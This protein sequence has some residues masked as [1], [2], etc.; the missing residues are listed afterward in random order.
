MRRSVWLVLLVLIGCETTPDVRPRYQFEQEVKMPVSCPESVEY[1]TWEELPRG[2]LG[3]VA[4][5]EGRAAAADGDWAL[6][7][8]WSHRAVDRAEPDDR[9]SALYG[10][11]E[12]RYALG[13]TSAVADD[14]ER[15]LAGRITEAEAASGH[16]YLAEIALDEG[17]IRDA[18]AHF[19]AVYELGQ[20]APWYPA[21]DASLGAIARFYP[22][23]D[24]ASLSFPRGMQAWV[25][26][27]DAE[28]HY[29]EGEYEEARQAFES[30]ESVDAM[31]RFGLRSVVA[32]RSQ[33]LRD[34]TDPVAGRIGMVLPLTGR[35]GRAGYFVLR[36]ALVSL[37]PFTNARLDLRILNDRSEPGR[38]AD[39]MQVLHG[40]GA[41]MVIGPL[42]GTS[43]REAVRAANRL[44]MPTFIFSSVDLPELAPWGV[45]SS[46]TPRQQVKALL[47]ESM[48]VKGHKRFAILYPEEPYGE[49]M[50]NAY[51]DEVVARGGQITAVESYQPG[52]TDFRGPIR[53]LAGSDTFSREEIEAL[54][55]R[56]QPL[57][58]LDFDAI[59]IPDGAPTAGLLIPQLIYYDVRGPLL[60]GTTAW[61]HPQLMEFGREYV[62]GSLFLD[63]FYPKSEDPFVQRFLE[64]YRVLYGDESPLSVSAQAYE[65]GLLA[66]EVAHLADRQQVRDFLYDNEWDSFK[67]PA[68]VLE[69]GDVE[70]AFYLLTVQRRQIIPVESTGTP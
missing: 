53:K 5:R 66:R 9:H 51:W 14:F 3:P 25:A 50:M 2:C 28:R 10:L 22:D 45:R 12:A 21:V 44:R 41:S 16:Y 46:V 30:L 18:L 58:R 65:A 40:E 56:N 61:H 48:G 15:A 37:D 23:V 43:A 11:T 33:D 39:A 20:G 60:M 59:F 1:E 35:A 70:R 57:A 6:A 68:R 34:R 13:E 17:R 55:E 36:G 47:D 24:R 7:R 63:W 52:S 31:A 54:E 67:G 42:M 8:S 29:R 62:E 64:E 32:A 27:M 4:L 19:A 26:F 49:T 69:N 38:T